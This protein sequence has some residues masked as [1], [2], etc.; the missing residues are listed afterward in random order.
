MKNVRI[1]NA[2]LQFRVEAFNVTNNTN[3]ALP[4]ANIF[5]STPNGGGAYSATAGRITSALAARQLQLAMKV[6][7]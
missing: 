4:N 5:S 3:F 6:T 2:N 1:Q 7:F